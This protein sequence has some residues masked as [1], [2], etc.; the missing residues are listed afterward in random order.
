MGI[1]NLAYVPSQLIVWNN[2]ETT[3]NNLVAHET[4]FR[5][6]ILSGLI[7]YI[8]FLV[9]PLILYKLL[10][11]VHKSYSLL[12]VLLAIVSVPISMINLEHKFSVLTLLS[13]ASSLQG[14][15]LYNLQEQVLFYLHAYTNGNK[16]ASIF[17]G[18]WLLPFGYLVFKSG[19][20]PKVLGILL[21]FG[22]FGYLINFI[23]NFLIPSYGETIFSDY[24][25]KPGSLGE[26]G[27]CLWLLIM[28]VKKRRN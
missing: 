2:A 16:I 10:K 19:F 27:T 11:P 4:L 23:G 18:L 26:I 25:T 24:I 3:F 5:I 20:I 15:A 6:G 22:C 7:C 12:M 8:A 13:N 21:M 14:N 17:W 1:I 9:L 28:G